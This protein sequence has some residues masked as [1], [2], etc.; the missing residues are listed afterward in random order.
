MT[1]I[2]IW[3]GMQAMD[4]V[5]TTFL[6]VIAFSAVVQ[7]VVLIG[8]A[9]AGGRL[10]RRLE[11]LADHLEVQMQPGLEH[12]TRLARSVADLSDQAA[13]QGR[14]VDAA[15]TDAVEKVRAS[16]G[17]VRDTVIRGTA[18]L[19][20]ISALWRGT[21]RALEVLRTGN[22]SAPRSRR[23]VRSSSRRAGT[24]QPG[25]PPRDDL[26]RPHEVWEERQTGATV[27]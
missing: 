21:R 19:I 14:R 5:S 17:F 20:E 23:A 22:G 1:D 25:P 24:D 16:A 27:R 4:N 15:V 11:E 10:M 7:A 12:V 3:H 2:A 13:V 6:G 18:P 26:G 9:I 8:L